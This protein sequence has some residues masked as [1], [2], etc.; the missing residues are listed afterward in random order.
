[1]YYAGINPLDMKKVYAPDDYREKLMQR[2]LLQYK[3]PEN[4][5][6]VREAL[7]KAG[8]ED[9]IGYGK[10]CLVAPDGREKEVRSAKGEVRNAKGKAQS[11]KGEVRSGRGGSTAKKEAQGTRGRSSANGKAQSAKFEVRSVKGKGKSATKKKG[12][13]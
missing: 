12:K 6:L 3:R 13:R 10:E 2:A 5:N 9:L 8:R 1:M 11:A 4:R 7:I